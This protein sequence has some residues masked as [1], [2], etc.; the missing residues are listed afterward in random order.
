M[1]VF[2]WEVT[3]YVLVMCI[4]V[5]CNNFYLYVSIQLK[6]EFS[7]SEVERSKGSK[8]Y[9]EKFNTIIQVS[10]NKLKQIAIN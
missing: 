9:V 6:K 5:K 8:D 1:L 2:A 4:K 7:S 3:N 10:Q